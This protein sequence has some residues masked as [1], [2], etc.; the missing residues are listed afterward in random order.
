MA[1]L[2]ARGRQELVRY[3]KSEVKNDAYHT[4]DTIN[5]HI[6]IMDDGKVLRKTTWTGYPGNWNEFKKLKKG[7]L[8]KGEKAT[9]DNFQVFIGNLEKNGYVRV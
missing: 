5:T 7:V 4:G 8:K 3:K 6:A 1:K 9:L 2:S